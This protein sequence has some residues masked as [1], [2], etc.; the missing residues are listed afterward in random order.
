MIVC[1][2]YFLLLYSVLIVDYASS[3]GNCME[4]LLHLLYCTTK[5][6]VIDEAVVALRQLLQQNVDHSPENINTNI[7]NIKYGCY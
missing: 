7:N 4:G 2:Q 5:D 1:L 6:K 3:A